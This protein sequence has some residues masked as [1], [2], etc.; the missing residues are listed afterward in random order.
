MKLNSCR[1]N[2]HLRCFPGRATT[3]R[4]ERQQQNYG[5]ATT[6]TPTGLQI[7]AN[8]WGF[9]QKQAHDYS[10]IINTSLDTKRRANVGTGSRKEEAGNE[11]ASCLYFLCSGSWRSR[12][13]WSCWLRLAAVAVKQQDS[14]LCVCVGLEINSGGSGKLQNYHPTWCRTGAKHAREELLCGILETILTSW[15]CFLSS[16]CDHFNS[17]SRVSRFLSRRCCCCYFLVLTVNRHTRLPLGGGGGCGGRLLG[18]VQ[19]FEE[20]NIKS[21]WES[22]RTKIPLSALPE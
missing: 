20:M 7:M 10:H 15:V 5:R 11:Y 22:S 8:R 12:S 13:P 6:L 3:T 17:H 14:S 9:R 21:M 4:V 1:I 2:G 19:V 16:Q 18:P